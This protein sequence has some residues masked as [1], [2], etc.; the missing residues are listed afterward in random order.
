MGAHVAIHL[1]PSCE[2]P[3]G[4]LELTHQELPSRGLLLLL[5]PGGHSKP[6]MRDSGTHGA[7]SLIVALL[8]DHQCLCGCWEEESVYW[9]FVWA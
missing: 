7:G 3:A 8:P 6:L 1:T 2:M 5:S 4:E 9:L